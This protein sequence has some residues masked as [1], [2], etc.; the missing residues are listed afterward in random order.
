L[1]GELAMYMLYLE[2]PA[3]RYFTSIVSE[4]GSFWYDAAEHDQ[5]DQYAPA[6]AMEAAMRN[7]SQSL[8]IDL[9]MAG[10]TFGNGTRV[11]FLYD[12]IAAQQ[13]QNL[14]L[15]HTTYMLGHV[16][17]DGPAFS[18]AMTFIFGD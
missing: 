7:A 1:S 5:G 18:D 10:D 6:V 4:E 11:T 16:P 8:P 14:H 13:F 9:V 3:H 12:T 15:I 2:D 17:M